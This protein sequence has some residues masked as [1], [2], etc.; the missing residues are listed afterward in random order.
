MTKVRLD[1][2]LSGAGLGTRNEMKKALRAARV[3]VNGEIVKDPGLHVVAGTD[4]V[5][6]DGE[7]VSYQE[8]VY[9]MMY[10]P[11]GVLS[12]TEDGRDPVVVDLL[13]DH[14]AAFDVFPVGRLDKD[15]EG[16]LLLT[17][18][19]KLAHQLLSPKKHVP[20]RYYVEVDGELTEADVDAIAKG[21]TLDDGYLCRPGSLLILQRGA[22]STAHITI[23]EGKFHQV[24]RMIQA[25]GKQV[26]FLKRIEM[27]PLSLDPD[28]EPGE[29]RPLT[30]SEI[31]TLLALRG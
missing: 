28:L 5:E 23:H 27:G 8:F 9:Y 18:D 14:D 19:G 29:Y 4:V 17:N 1:K 15:A 13:D 3:R 6:F 25:V 12:A 10:K 7:P 31:E 2:W 26:T 22:V 30:E 21:V 24:K 16:L 11:Q 20:K